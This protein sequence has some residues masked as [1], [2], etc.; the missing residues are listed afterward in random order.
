MPGRGRDG[1]AAQAS[2]VDSLADA[3]I[4][5]TAL[6]KH[7]RMSPLEQQASRETQRAD[8][9]YFKAHPT[10]ESYVR[11]YQ[12]G[13]LPPEMERGYGPPTHVAVG[14]VCPGERARVFL[15]PGHL[16]ATGRLWAE[17]GAERERVRRGL[18][19]SA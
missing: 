11:A 15:W 2:A 6:M 14:L 4:D 7:V 8:M 19:A 18:R 10:A 12:S 13:E 3:P 5:L 9:A 16:H 1:K 17:K